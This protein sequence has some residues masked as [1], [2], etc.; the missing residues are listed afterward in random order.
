MRSSA[1]RKEALY[2]LYRKRE[3]HQMS[4]H[5]NAP[6]GAWEVSEDFLLACA[7]LPIYHGNSLETGI[8]FSTAVFSAFGWSHT[9]IT[10]SRQEA[11]GL[12]NWLRFLNEDLYV[13]PK[14]ITK[15]SY[16]V[17]PELSRQNAASLDFALID[18]NHAWPHVFLDYFYIS[19]ML[20]P[21]AFLAIDDTNLDAPLGLL[22]YLQTRSYWSQVSSGDKWVILQL[23]GKSS[24]ETE[25]WNS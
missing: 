18:G 5:L 4:V 6:T 19:L 12:E 16:E 15:P 21:G 25:D 9:G 7:D 13:K 3:K 14:L 24:V 1:S 23:V 8:G 20:A 11:L 17:L 22:R 2:D 10:P